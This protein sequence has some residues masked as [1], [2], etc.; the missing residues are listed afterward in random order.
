MSNNQSN[1][2]QLHQ[3]GIIKKETMS[4]E[5]IKAIDALSQEEV[6]HLKASNLSNRS[7]STTAGIIL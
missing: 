1:S 5:S 7:V 3:A 2:E 4:L 6:G